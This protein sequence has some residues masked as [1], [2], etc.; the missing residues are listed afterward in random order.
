MARFGTRDSLV[1]APDR[2]EIRVDVLWDGLTTAC[3]VPRKVL[4]DLVGLH[5][6]STE[7]L[8]DVARDHYPLLTD[9]WAQR[10]SCGKREPD[11]SVLLRIGDLL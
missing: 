2:D 9:A 7:D 8:L 11:G 4:E 6:L 1:P 3:R 5:G 10:L